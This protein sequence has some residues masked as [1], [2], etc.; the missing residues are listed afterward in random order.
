MNRL[1]RQFLNLERN[2]S[3]LV[4]ALIVFFLGVSLGTEVT[5]AAGLENY[6]APLAILGSPLTL[7]IIRSQGRRNRI[8][9]LVVLVPLGIGAYIY[10]SGRMLSVNNTVYDFKAADIETQL[11][12][13]LHMCDN[14]KCVF[15]VDW[16]CG[17]SNGDASAVEQCL[18]LAR[19]ILTER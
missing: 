15:D 8:I 19:G 9:A 17:F 3:A 11:R 16:K 5:R 10:Y 12:Y 7:F 1:E 13:K 18:E 14:G 2:A 4:A 6:A